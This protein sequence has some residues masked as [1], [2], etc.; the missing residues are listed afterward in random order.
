[1]ND[2]C[3]F[4]NSYH[5]QLNNSYHLPRM[6]LICKYNEE[7]GS[8]IQISLLSYELV[9]LAISMLFHMSVFT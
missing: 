8:L 4:H 5:V 9:E 3:S 7:Y 6:V 2:S 1:M